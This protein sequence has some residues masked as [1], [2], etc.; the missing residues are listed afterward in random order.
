M[1]AVAYLFR[2]SLLDRYDAEDFGRAINET[3]RTRYLRDAAT[4]VIEAIHGLPELMETDLSR[5]EVYIG[6]SAASAYHI[7]GRWNA[8]LD[9]FSNAPSTH[10]LIAARTTTD[11]LRDEKWERTAQ[12]VINS[13]V[14]H[15]ALCCSNALTGDSGRWPSDE[16]SIIYLVARLRRGKPSNGVDAGAL[17]HAVADLLDDDDLPHDVVREVGRAILHP[18]R[19]AEHEHVVLQDDDDADDETPE[20]PECK[21]CWRRARPGNYGFCGVHRAMVAGGSAV[22]RVCGRAAKSGNYGFC[23][24]HRR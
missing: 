12:R 10:A 22:C 1:T 7:R 3:R 20:A 11:R 24:Y 19:G 18:E 13:L 2:L 8:R 21:T 14:Q 4:A 6:R 17:N 9:A 15:N 16:E 5:L 23:G